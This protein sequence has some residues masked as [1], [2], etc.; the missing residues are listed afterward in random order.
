MALPIE[1]LYKARDFLNLKNI[2][3]NHVELSFKNPVIAMLAK[4][5]V[6]EIAS[7]CSPEGAFTKCE[8]HGNDL[9]LD[10]NPEYV[11]E[12][13][14]AEI[15][16]A[17]PERAKDAARELA[18]F[19]A[20]A[21]FTFIFVLTVLGTTDRDNSSPHFAGLAIGLTLVLVHIVCIPVTGTSVNPAR[22]IG[23]ALFAGVEA[24]SQLWLFIVAPIVGAVVAV[25]VW[26]I[27][28]GN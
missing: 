25:P 11:S 2:S 15:F 5:K 28:K 3:A 19:V 24:I 16:D 27:I 23:P 6:A 22:S 26:K 8:M 12:R 10:F 7:Q 17:A 18:A 20:E 9:H 14:M 13:L 4:G 21:V 1:Q